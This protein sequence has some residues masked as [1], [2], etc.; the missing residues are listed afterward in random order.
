MNSFKEIHISPQV[1]ID[2][3]HMIQVLF[4]KKKKKSLSTGLTGL[5]A[6]TQKRSFQLVLFSVIKIKNGF[7]VV[8]QQPQKSKQTRFLSREASVS[9]RPGQV[10]RGRSSPQKEE[11]ALAS[12]QDGHTRSAASVPLI[13]SKP[14][15]RTAGFQ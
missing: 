13:G 14:N 6:R 8:A 9:I 7:K 3:N 2:P 11:E 12:R 5:L 4:F 1:C 10:L 15:W